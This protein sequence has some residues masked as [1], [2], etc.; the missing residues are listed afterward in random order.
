M[1]I[2]DSDKKFE[3]FNFHTIVIDGNDFDQI[4]AAFEEAKKTKGQPTAIIAKT[5]KAVSYTHLRHLPDHPAAHGNS[6]A[7]KHRWQVRTGR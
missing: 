3:A 7:R 6:T 1:C 4:R 2:R 5:I